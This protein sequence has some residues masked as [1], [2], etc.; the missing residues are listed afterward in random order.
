M[1]KKKYHIS[2]FDCP[3]CAHKSEE[4]LAKQES[5][6]SC[7]IDF[8]TNKMYITYK[9]E[10]LSVQEIADIIAQV[11]SD[12]LDIRDLDEKVNKK[13]YHISVCLQKT[14]LWTKYLVAILCS[15]ERV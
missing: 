9:K 1:I 6:E 7:H 8:S 15:G 5:I 13:I 2:G 12:P 11:E 3:N 10:Q 14:T 4:H